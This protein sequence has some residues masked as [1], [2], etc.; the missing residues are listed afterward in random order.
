MQKSS[1]APVNFDSPHG[2][3]GTVPPLPR[4]SRRP[5]PFM[6]LAEFAPRIPAFLAR[7]AGMGGAESEARGAQDCAK[8]SPMVI[9]GRTFKTDNGGAL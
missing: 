7:S 9:T 4:V 2:C 1:P 5:G 6:S 3:Y 8:R